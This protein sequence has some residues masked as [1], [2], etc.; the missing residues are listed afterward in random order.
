MSTLLQCCNAALNR[1]GCEFITA[2][3]DNNK[4]AKICNEI[5]TR[6]RQKTLAEYNW[7][8]ALVTVTSTGTE[9]TRDDE[10][11][12]QHDLPS[13]FLKMFKIEEEDIQYRR[14][15][16]YIFADTNELVYTY[17]SDIDD[18]ADLSVGFKEVFILKMAH[19]ASY[20]LANSNTLRN[21]L[22]SEL[23]EVERVYRNADSLES[24][25]HNAVSANTHKYA[26]Y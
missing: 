8:F 9:V 11:S 7:K 19:E 3:T 14:E 17:V 12:S 5:Y 10:L 20:S 24:N 15:G 13:D 16:A 26:R 25:Y 4:R 2:L 18:F 22:N 6:I 1:I 23:I 21:D